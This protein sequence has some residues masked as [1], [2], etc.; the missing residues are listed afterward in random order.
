[1]TEW[2][3]AVATETMF[4]VPIRLEDGPGHGLEIEVPAPFRLPPLV[5]RPTVGG[6]PVAYT[7]DRQRSPEPGMPWRYTWFPW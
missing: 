4:R 3:E 5:V 7:R 6:R 2:N 1:M